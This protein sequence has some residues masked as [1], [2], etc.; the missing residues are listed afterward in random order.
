MVAR[1][2]PNQEDSL[3]RSLVAQIRRKSWFTH[4]AALFGDAAVF[5]GAAKA[6]A[7]AI[8]DETA[9]SEGVFGLNPR[10]PLFL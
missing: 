3:S 1:M 8:A 2:L 6:Q 9:C 10:F 5:K 7:A 4:E